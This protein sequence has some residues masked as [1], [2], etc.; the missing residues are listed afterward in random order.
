[1]VDLHP[2]VAFDSDAM[3]SNLDMQGGYVRFQSGS[4]AAL[5]RGTASS[6]VD[7]H[8]AHASNSGIVGMSG[9][10]QV[11]SASLSDRAAGACLW[12]GSAATWVN[13]APPGSSESLAY[14]TDNGRQVG[15]AQFELGRSRAVLWNG[16][17]ESWRDLTPPDASA[18][19]FAIS[20]NQQVG[21]VDRF[22]AHAALWSGSADSLI[23]LNPSYSTESYAF[24]VFDGFQ[25]GY[26][27]EGY[28]RACLWIGSADSCENLSALLPSN[29]AHSRATSV[30]HD[31]TT[32]YVGGA[33]QNMDTGR[34]EA[35]AWSRPI[36]GPGSLCVL[37]VPVRLYLSR[38]RPAP[39]VRSS[40]LLKN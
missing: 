27:E 19:A 17:A 36:P 37:V 26:F 4:H 5:W 20:G 23:D 18:Q 24:D 8:P 3:C 28:Y 14:D 7:L 34:M 35:W 2:P 13:L 10:Q 29:Y 39:S 22:A 21:Y 15:S 16:S 33:A 38:R 1:M 11:G 6:W 32:V 31:G 12:T 40:G 9:D 30:W 25:V